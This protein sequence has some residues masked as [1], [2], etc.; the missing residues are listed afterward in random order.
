MGV[1]SMQ[2]HLRSLSAQLILLAGVILAAIGLAPSIASAEMTI[3][4]KY[5][6]VM[7]MVRPEQ[8]AGIQV[9]HNLRIVFT[10]RAVVEKRDRNTKNLQDRN[11]TDQDLGE[12]EPTDTYVS[13]RV[14]SKTRLV[15]TQRDP[16]STRTMTV[17][18]LPGNTCHLD[19]VDKLSPGFT[20]YAFLR[21]ASHTLGYF[22]TYRVLQTSCTVE[23]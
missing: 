16:Q 12:A 19:V 2:S 6:S 15:R 4:L 9:H 7:D 11:A 5:D 1:V 23:P 13:W 22:S 10:G 3:D 20:E 21:I 8:R 18:L 14:A 17:T